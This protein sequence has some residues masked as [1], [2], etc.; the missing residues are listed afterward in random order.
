MDF[1]LLKYFSVV[2]STQHMTKAAKILNIS[3]PSLS[4]AIR[5]LEH[6]LGFELFT[7]TKRTIELNEY[8]MLFLE[9]VRAIEADYAQGLSKMNE[10]RKMQDEFVTL[11]IPNSPIKHRLVDTLLSDGFNLK[12][13]ALPDNWQQ[14]LFNNKIDL[15]ITIEEFSSAKFK[16]TLLRY[17]DIVVVSNVKHPLTKKKRISVEDVNSY[18][19]SVTST[20]HSPFVCARDQLTANGIRPN[21]TFWGNNT[22]DLMHSFYSSERLGLMIKSHLPIDH[23]LAILPVEDLHISLP[24]YLYWRE[25]NNKEPVN[26]I[27]RRIEDFYSH[28]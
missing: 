6:E 17:N 19:F 15:V 14:A 21:V 16:R 24:I 23:N 11:C 22:A 5:R 18:P 12:L 9:C 27:I 2:A 26:L 7:R 13:L 25:D 4:S 1:S 10:L 8:G 20:P 28:L 3:Q